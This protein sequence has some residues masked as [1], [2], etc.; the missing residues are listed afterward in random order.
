MTST[1][2]NN[3]N[4]KLP[5]VEEFYSL[6]G[7]G[8][9]MGKVAYFVR[10]GGCD[11]GCRWCDSA[12]T[13]DPSVF[14][15]IE[16]D[17]IIEKA[18]KYSAREV[19]IT[20]GEPLMW[21]LNYLCEV[22]KSKGFKTFLETSGAY[23]LSGNWDW[24]CLSPKKQA[25]PLPEIYSLAD[26][27]KIIVAEEDDFQWA[28]KN[29]RLVR[30]KCHLFLQPEWSVHKSITPV[31]VEFIKHHPEWRISLQAHKFMKIP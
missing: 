20:G 3:P 25:P 5:I 11:I 19:V 29:A 7:E 10:I 9:H 18:L 13:W 30:K 24:I 23:S 22:F 17:T 8:F 16:I 15:E 21:N 26:E 2:S 6:Q 12:F 14:P 1:V 31:I 4:F 28:V 27:L